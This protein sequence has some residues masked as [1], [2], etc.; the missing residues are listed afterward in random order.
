MKNEI[1]A[2]SAVAK[3]LQ[4][5]NANSRGYIYRDDLLCL[6]YLTDE[7]KGLLFDAVN[8]MLFFRDIDPASFSDPMLQL[9]F[10]PIRLHILRDREAYAAKCATNRA[11]SNKRFETKSMGQ[12]QTAADKPVDALIHEPSSTVDERWTA[13][14]IGGVRIEAAEFHRA[15]NLFF[16]LNYPP[17]Q[18]KACY[19]YYG[20]RTNGWGQWTTPDARWN[21]AISSWRNRT[22]RQ[23]F[24]ANILA[25][26]GD[27]YDMAPAVIQNCITRPDF[28]ITPKEGAA[29]FRYSKDSPLGAW[30]M[31]NRT[32]ITEIA[33]KYGFDNIAGK[34][35][36]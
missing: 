21:N 29:V 35:N 23:R 25:M 22:G 31:G 5:Y 4:L 26:V 28:D 17:D 15:N 16:W 7:Q 12:L 2:S 32:R 11:N 20:R 27:V 36:D 33:Y 3:E 34:N 1:L 14:E 19:D 24:S 30:L 8:T 6:K 13:Q 10:T 18:I 9:A